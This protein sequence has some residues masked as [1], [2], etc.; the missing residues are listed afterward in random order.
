MCYHA[1]ESISNLSTREITWGGRKD[2]F[3][4]TDK[5]S[6]PIGQVSQWDN[7]WDKANGTRGTMGQGR[8][9]GKGD[10]GTSG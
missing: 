10:S 9:M 7:Q 5:T 4:N 6:G 3:D 1:T 2:K 8:H